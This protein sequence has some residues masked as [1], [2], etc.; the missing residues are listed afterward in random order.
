M[1]CNIENEV[2]FKYIETYHQL[3]AVFINHFFLFL[4]NGRQKN[5]RDGD[6][7]SLYWCVCDSLLVYLICL[8]G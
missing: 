8:G 6:A 3:L 1:H 5:L 7:V 2:I 4:A